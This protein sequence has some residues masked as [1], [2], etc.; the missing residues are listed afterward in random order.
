MPSLTREI[1]FGSA[2]HSK[3]LKMLEGRIKMAQRDQQKQH[4]RWQ[5]AEDTVLCYVPESDL[6]ASRKADRENSGTPRYTTIKL[7]YTYALLLSQHTYLTSVFFSRSPIHQFTGR[8]GEGEQQVQAMEALIAHQIEV[9][10]MIGPY[11]VWLYDACK[12]GVGVLE[13]YWED[14]RSQFSSLQMMPDPKDPTGETMVKGLMR[15]QMP[16]YQGTK[17]SNISPW[18]FFP[19]PRVTVGRYQTGEFIF[20]RKNL[21]WADVVK[22]KAR[23]F[24][25]NVEHITNDVKDFAGTTR[26]ANS[27]NSQLERPDE[28]LMLEDADDVK[29]PAVVPVYEGCVEVIPR[30][31][32]LH[33]SDFPE[34]WMFT[35]TGDLKTLIGCQPHGAMH[36]KFPY[37]VIETEIE[38]YGSGGR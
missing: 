14:E 22:R 35:L 20:V 5:K 6:D 30:E 37:A 26:G 15:V 4:P 11:Y 18:D 38:G 3:L 19:D 17:I 9:G 21:S 24:Y 1:P 16:G 2:L 12:Y 32:G 34:K 31:W 23:G 29:H 25:M 10:E 27:N 36:C 33:D 7:P 28:S 13:E 8:H